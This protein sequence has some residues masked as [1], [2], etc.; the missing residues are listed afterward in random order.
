MQKYKNLD[1]AQNAYQT[2]S[3]IRSLEIALTEKCN[4]NCSYCGAYK[5]NGGCISFQEIMNAVK[6][7]N[8]VERIILSGGE[9]TLNF[10]ECLSVAKYCKAA[11][12]ELQL[13]TNGSLLN[14]DMI[15]ELKKAGLHTIHISLNHYNRESHASY[16]NVPPSTFDTIMG[17][18]SACS[19][20]IPTCVVE[21]ILCEDF[22]WN[23]VK[24]NHLISDL[25]VTKHEIQYGITNNHWKNDV[26]EENVGKVLLELFSTKSEAMEIFMTCFRLKPFGKYHKL[27]EQYIKQGKV[28]FTKCIEGHH[29]FHLN[30]NGDLIVCDIGFPYVLGN[31]KDGLDLS[32]LDFS[33]PEMK[34]FHKEHG[35]KKNCILS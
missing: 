31:I 23:I 27:F 4:F 24:I 25:H 17:N 14:R 13:N 16:Y 11:D 1:L 35:C 32:N 10:E 8:T 3:E 30:N 12:I 9:V 19:E 6:S 7:L 29:Q 21:S 33:T 20:L 18:I 34:N 26:C 28:H 15:V 2:P 5:S 22:I